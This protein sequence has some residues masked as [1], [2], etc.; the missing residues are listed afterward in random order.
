MC[1]NS[2]YPQQR[3]DRSTEKVN[4]ISGEY[5]NDQN[6]SVNDQALHVGGITPIEPNKIRSI[7]V[8][9]MEFDD[10]KGWVTRKSKPDPT[11]NVLIYIYVSMDT[12]RIVYHTII[13]IL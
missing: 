1:R 6:Y 9:H 2:R 8:P 10:R 3:L 13:H 12:K 5:I 7:H 11:I 4:N